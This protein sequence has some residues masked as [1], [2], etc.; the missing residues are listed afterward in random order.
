MPCQQIKTS[1]R[2]SPVSVSC[3]SCGI[4]A[5]CHSVG[6]DADLS[7]LDTLVRSRRTIKR[8]EVLY[9]AGEPFRAIYAIRGGSTKTFILADDGRVQVTGFQFAGEVL[10]LDA[11]TTGHYNCTATAMETTG[12]CEV[13]FASFDELGDEFPDLQR[14]ML[15]VM[16]HEILHCH[17]LMMLLGKRNAEERLATFLLN[18]SGRLEKR[19]FSHT[20]FSMSMS[21][22]DIGN[23][24]GMAEET[25][26]R[27]FTRLQEDGVI[28][29]QRRHITLNSL[30]QL[31]VMACRKQAA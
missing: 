25:V 30:D 19:N 5:L 2:L 27:V 7:V 13:P 26:S 23:Y 28:T 4:F 22:S 21:R 29:I 31:R 12:V 24:L 6:G 16:S 1:P 3:D 14:G 17:E 18:M 9:R 15:E 10:G 8:G 11:I 20:Q